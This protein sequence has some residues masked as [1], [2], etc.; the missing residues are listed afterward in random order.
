MNLNKKTV[1]SV[2]FLQ[3]GERLITG[4][5]DQQLKI[6]ELENFKVS[7]QFKYDD[8]ILNFDLN[9]S[10]SHIAVGLT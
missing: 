4:S 2:K 7:H 5:L 6:F 10:G 1:T 3:N 9:P 8:G